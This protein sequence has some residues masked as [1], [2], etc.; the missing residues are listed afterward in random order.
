MKIEIDEA[1]S[2]VIKVPFDKWKH[3]IKDPVQVSSNETPEEVRKRVF[4]TTDPDNEFMSRLSE[5]TALIIND[6]DIE[7]Q[8]Y[9]SGVVLETG[10]SFTYIHESWFK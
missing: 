2:L 8:L 1:G 10:E 5:K 9:F 3:L 6:Y 7:G 4:K